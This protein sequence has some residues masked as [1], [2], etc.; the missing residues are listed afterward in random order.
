MTGRRRRDTQY[1]TAL[2][3]E[4]DFIPGA[5]RARQIR[6]KS[7]FRHDEALQIGF[8]SKTEAL[9]QFR[10]RFSEDEYSQIREEYKTHSMKFLPHPTMDAEL[11]LTM[12]E[13]AG[14]STVS[15]QYLR[16]FQFHWRQC[17]RCLVHLLKICPSRFQLIF[18]E[19]ILVQKVYQSKA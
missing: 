7:Q 9:L 13:K 16:L 4:R 5:N 11:C 2:S 12:Y 19:Q 10:K 6:K 14:I 17:A 1:L 15:V 3:K 8:R 18:Y